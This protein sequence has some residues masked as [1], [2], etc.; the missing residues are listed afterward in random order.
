M[1]SRRAREALL[2]AAHSVIL[3]A[4]T[5]A[6]AILDGLNGGDPPSRI[7]FEIGRASM[8]LRL[9]LP[10]PVHLPGQGKSP[11]MKESTS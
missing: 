2:A 5:D 3:K 1:T 8:T 4:A 9:A 10:G 11:G 7:W 6:L